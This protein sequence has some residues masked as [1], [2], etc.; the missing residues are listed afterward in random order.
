MPSS[1]GR[2]GAERIGGDRHR[3][4]P[5]SDARCY[6]GADPDRTLLAVQSETPLD[7]SRATGRSASPAADPTRPRRL[8]RW[9]E[10]ARPVARP[11][12]RRARF[13][14]AIDAWMVHLL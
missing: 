10:R 9:V 14:D 6:A 7:T 1:S 13:G 11:S 8:D 3:P 5:E 12:S 4:S 2:A